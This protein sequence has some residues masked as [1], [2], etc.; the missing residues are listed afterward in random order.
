VNAT[1]AGRP[2]GLLLV[3]AA[4]VL[5]GLNLRIAVT[6]VGPVLQEIQQGL[7]ISSAA[8]G[9][10]TTMPVL[11]F[12]LIGFVGPSL[13]ARFRDGHV[14]AGALLVMAAGL[15]L[16]AVAGTFWLF[17]P[18][19]VLAMVGG[20]LGNV[21]LPSLVKR[22][23]PHR[24]GALV[25]AYSTA[26]AIGA[27][28]VAISTAPIAAAAGD[29]GWRWALGVWAVLPLVAAVPWLFVPAAR[30]AG[31]GGRAAVPM[32]PLVRSPTAVALTV[33]FGAQSI[34]AYVVIGWSA[35]YLRDSGLAAGTAGLLLGLNQL[36]AIPV[37]AVVPSLTV[38]QG[39][40]RPLL[41]GF[42]ACY[43][44]GWLGLWL[45]P[46][47]VPW[48][49]MIVLA[50][51]MGVFPMV[52]TLI[53]LRARAPETVA[54]LSTVTQSWGYLLAASGPLLVGLLRGATGS[55]TGMFVLVLTCVAVL[56]G[57]GWLATRPR[58]VD[59]ELPG[60]SP[61]HPAPGAPIGVSPDAGSRPG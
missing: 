40:Q 45:A 59:D 31:R 17:L 46:L 42:V 39:V 22:H 43:V 29:G 28:V 30:G 60:W 16:R 1:G 9:L 57:T 2:H 51:G 21:L 35:Q 55:Y 34:M 19:T 41:A 18:G 32:A 23:F 3:G 53:G 54:A 48:A 58:F 5:T 36:V 33:L 49:W 8:A 20:A 15:V 44:A 37:S 11:C 13:A 47:T 50:L 52:L 25:G 14:L 4:I 7:A 12:A 56:T 61:A 6:S 10:V 26:M 27:A 38:R 24:T